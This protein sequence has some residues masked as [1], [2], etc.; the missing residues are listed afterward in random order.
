[1]LRKGLA[2]GVESGES[3]F[4]ETDES[5]SEAGISSPGAFAGTPEF[6]SPEQFAGVGVEIRSDLCSLGVTLLGDGNYPRCQQ[7]SNPG[8]RAL[9]SH[10]PETVPLR[11]VLLRHCRL[12]CIF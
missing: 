4:E 12:S 8:N 11:G 2:G 10:V 5:A 1:M 9:Y 6:A 3:S 7:G